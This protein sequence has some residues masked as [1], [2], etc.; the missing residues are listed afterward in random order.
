M[1]HYLDEALEKLLNKGQRPQN[2]MAW[3]LALWLRNT[4]I[5]LNCNIY[6]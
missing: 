3:M 5:A 1:Y 4:V 6:R 2:Y